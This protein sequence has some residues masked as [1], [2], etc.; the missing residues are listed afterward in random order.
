MV[1]LGMTPMEAIV[2]STAA[3]ARLI[4]IQDSVGILTKGMEAD[5]VILQGNPLRGIEVLGDRDRIV[6]VMKAGTFVAG[7]LSR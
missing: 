1:A 6:G 3:A 7:P 4:G 5:L 2:A